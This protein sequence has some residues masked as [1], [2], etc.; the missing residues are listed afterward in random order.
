[1]FTDLQTCFRRHMFIAVTRSVSLKSPALMV[2]GNFNPRSAGGG[3]ILPP[4]VFSYLILYILNFAPPPKKNQN[5][6]F[7]KINVSKDYN[8]G[9]IQNTGIYVVKF[10]ANNTHIKIPRHLL[11]L[12][13]QWQKKKQVKVVTSFS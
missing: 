1:M 9:V 8:F 10:Y 13:V 2:A 6:D 12:A 7:A 11:Y 3:G 5:F 4:P